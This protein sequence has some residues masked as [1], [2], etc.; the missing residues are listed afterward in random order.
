MFVDPRE[1]RGENVLS[2]Y[3]YVCVWERERER[4][5]KGEREIDVREKH[6]SIASYMYPD[7][8]LN[9]Q[10][11]YVPWQRIKTITFLCTGWLSNQLIH[12]ARA[13]GHV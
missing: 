12:P 10:P 8:G 13:P 4:K 9:L 11:R 6:Q 3:V 2:V 7:W 1:E 5:R